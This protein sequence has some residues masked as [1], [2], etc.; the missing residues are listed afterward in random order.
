MF[1]P[2]RAS[3]SLHNGT[4]WT[5]HF[6]TNPD[7]E[8]TVSESL[9]V[10]MS[11]LSA[12]ERDALKSEDFAV[13]GKRM[14]PIHDPKHIRMAWD[15]VSRAR[16]LTAEERAA[17]RNRILAAAKAH[18][19]DT[20]GWSKKEVTDAVVVTDSVVTAV[21]VIEDAQAPTKGLLRG[22]FTGTR[23]NV[24]NDNNRVY[25]T[26]VLSDAVGRFKAKL[27]VTGESP[28]PAAKRGVQGQVIFDGRLENSVYNIVDA[29]MDG[30]VLRFVA[31]VMGTAKGKDL[32]A[33]IDAGGKVGVS[34]RATGS[35]VERVIDGHTVEVMT[36]L[37]IHSFDQVQNPAT[38]ACGLEEVLT[39][40]QVEQILHDA[41]QGGP[42]LCPD[43]GTAMEPQDPDHDGDVDFYTCP[44]CGSV[45][46]EDHDLHQETHTDTHTH[47]HA[48]HSLQKVTPANR[49]RH[50]HARRWMDSHPPTKPT[51]DSVKEGE[52][53]K[54][55]DLIKAMREDPAVKAAVAE[56]AAEVAKPALDATEEKKAAEDALRGL[57]RQ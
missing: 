35:G 57:P 12:K 29:Y 53:M 47:A 16:N 6:I 54:T 11:D 9:E 52:I 31:D 46:L 25:P 8:A 28:H 51:T 19:I 43:D 32:K 17:A 4:T 14:L 50:D 21:E 39:D 36:H 30:P 3:R 49:E 10:P 2:A 48:S 44:N 26:A 7:S 13:P 15:M 40:A 38:D 20:G 22:R 5:H 41:A 37:D 18:G 42:P 23:A 45:F 24:I 34:M 33:V 55:E 27:P 56:L 1:P